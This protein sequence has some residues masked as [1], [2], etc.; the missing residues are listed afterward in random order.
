MS[1]TRGK[2]SDLENDYPGNAAE[3]LAERGLPR[4]S[5]VCIYTE[6][7]HTNVYH[8]VVQSRFR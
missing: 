6:Q 4:V 7:A 3:D 2:T 1:G 5:K 8:V